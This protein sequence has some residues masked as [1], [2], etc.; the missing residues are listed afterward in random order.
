ML[1]MEYSAFPKRNDGIFTS[2]GPDSGNILTSSIG[3]MGR[4]I[5]GKC[6]MT[7][8]NLTLTDEERQDWC[9]TIID[10]QSNNKPWISFSIKNKLMSLTGYSFR[11]G[12]C[13]YS[14]C[15]INED[16]VINDIDGC[17]CELHSFSLQGSNDNETWKTIHQVDSNTRI[18]YC[19]DKTYNFDSK[20]QPFKYIRFVK[21]K[22]KSGCPFCLQI[23]QF[24]FYGD[25][26]DA[27][28][29]S[30][31]SFEE[32]EESVSIIGKIKRDE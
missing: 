7:S 6:Q 19:E 17:C 29:S 10:K 30:Y 28:D 8:P 31:S 22:E 16:G 23:N 20:T 25:T 14:C 11:N 13:Y 21:D 27:L 9:S 32:E 3:S 18:R 2:I 26:V 12:C 15:C 1:F 24:E 5:R 4:Y